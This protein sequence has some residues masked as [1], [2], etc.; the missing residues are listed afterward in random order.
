MN[1]CTYCGDETEK[2]VCDECRINRESVECVFGLTGGELE[3]KPWV[4]TSDNGEISQKFAFWYEGSPDYCKRDWST[5]TRTI[6]FEGLY[7]SAPITLVDGTG[8]WTKFA[9]FT[10][11]GECECPHRNADDSEDTDAEIA[12]DDSTCELCG[13]T[14]GDGHGFIYLGD[15]YSE[16]VYKVEPE[17]EEP[18]TEE[19][20]AE[21]DPVLASS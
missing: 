6:I 11:S 14:D 21:L 5:E 16:V 20:K 7:S 19:D 15:G 9:S 17:I 2:I 3:D 4:C 12:E 1:L 13:E 10:S 8:T 18:E